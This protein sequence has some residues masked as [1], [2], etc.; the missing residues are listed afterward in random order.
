[1]ISNTLILKAFVIFTSIFIFS[2]TINKQIYQKNNDQTKI[3]SLSGTWKFSN[4][5]LKSHNFYLS[6]FDDSVWED[7]K[8]PSNWYL[9]GK[10]ISGYAVYRKHFLISPNNKNKYLKLSFIGVDYTA[11]VW[12]NGSYIG[13]HEGYF[14][15]FSFDI[16]DKIN[17]KS[18][19]V[20]TVMVN[21]PNEEID[22]S[23]SLNKRLI[24]GVFNHHDTRPGGAWSNRGQEK[25]TGGI[26]ND[27]L[28][29]SSDYVSLDNIQIKTSI[30]KEYNDSDIDLTFK[31]DSQTSEKLR[32]EFFVKP[33]N[34]NPKQQSGSYLKTS[35]KV[36]KGNN[37]YDFKIR[38]SNTYFWWL[39][40]M[41]KPNLYELQIKIYKKDKLIEEKK[42]TFGFRKVFVDKNKVFYINDKKV[43]L[44]GTNYISTQWLSEMNKEKYLKDI[45]L[46]KNANVNTVRVHAHIEDSEFYRQCD[47]Q[48]LMVW[49]DFPLQWGYIDNEEFTKQALKQE[50]EMIDLLNNNP[51]VISWSIHNEP[52]WDASW[53]KY[54]YHNYNPEQNKT[55]DEHLYQQ[56]IK[57]DTTRFVQKYSS[58]NSHPWFGWYSGDWKDYLK[59]TKEPI[60]EEYGAEAIPNL[61]TLKTIFPKESIF[62][63]S[64]KDWELWDYHNFQKKETFENAKVKQGKNINEF[65]ANTQNYQANLIKVAAESFR[66]QKY[67]P[68]TGIFQFMFVESWKSVNWGIIDY[69]RNEK[70]GYDYLKTAYQPILPS[71]V[72]EKDTYKKDELIKLQLWAINDLDKG[73]D[74]SSFSYILKD[75]NNIIEKKSI[76]F[77]LKESSS[78]KIEVLSFDKLKPNNYEL[79]TQINSND[80]VLLGKNRLKFKIMN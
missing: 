50:F 75:E 69:L 27:V 80:S 13:F 19:N 3:R 47:L 79:I 44:R 16:S 6:D 63:K 78:T 9:T 58:T 64:E 25:N 41:G 67:K 14:K 37:N 57:K 2:C 77:N 68:V 5:N 36:K 30:N 55:L 26:W 66:R 4:Q 28:I 11:D 46:M 39:W 52:P 49:Q 12:L 1:M 7:I 62:P 38:N 22:K 33:L 29:Q 42:Q 40:E 20:L 34:F 72:S 15:D 61:S 54:K 56:L 8:V 35:E 43:F 59:P 65:I 21:S 73:F 60:I 17:F 48:G 31:L 51:S 32:F 23:W 53:M 70:K 10:D 74:S 76:I 18:D 45:L 71:V 24:K